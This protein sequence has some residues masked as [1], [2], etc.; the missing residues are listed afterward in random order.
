MT[1]NQQKGLYKFFYVFYSC[2]HSCFLLGIKG[3][4]NRYVFEIKFTCSYDGYRSIY[5]V[6]VGGSSQ[7]PLQCIWVYSIPSPI[8]GAGFY[9]ENAAGA[10]NR[11]GF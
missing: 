2:F 1:Q 5:A 11:L 10:K 8:I 4:D 6:A 7:L 9:L 3:K